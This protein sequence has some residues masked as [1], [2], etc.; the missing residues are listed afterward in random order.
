MASYTYSKFLHRMHNSVVAPLNK[1]PAFDKPRDFFTVKSDDGATIEIPMKYFS[2]VAAIDVISP[3]SGPR[4][5]HS[6]V[7]HIQNRKR[8]TLVDKALDKL[9][10]IGIKQ[11]VKQPIS[12]AAKAMLGAAAGKGAGV[13]V[14]LLQ[15]DDLGSSVFYDIMH[16]GKTTDGRDVTFYILGDPNK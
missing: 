1:G 12:L 9:T 16:T 6:Y 10:D 2:D 5:A 14:S 15:A 13:A 4:V 7:V 8:Q 11:S 3:G